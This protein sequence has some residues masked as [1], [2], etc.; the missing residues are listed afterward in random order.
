MKNKY[1]CL[2]VDDEPLALEAIEILVNDF[3]QFHIVAKCRNAFSALEILSKTDIDLVFLDINMPKL[4]G[5]DFLSISKRNFKVILTT[6]YREYALESYDFD[7]LD[8]LLKPI[9]ADRFSKAI[10]KFL[11][12][13]KSVKNEATSSIKTSKEY[14]FVRQDRKDVK[15][16][17]KEILFIEGMKDYIIIHTKKEKLITKKTLT[18]FSSELPKD[19]FLRVHKSYIVSIDKIKSISPDGIEINDKLIPHSKT[20]KDNIQN[21]ID[22]S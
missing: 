1:K 9:K 4:S 11:E 16:I 19:Q 17:L 2:I 13:S 7:V 8:Y 10:T 15:I 18:L 3:S 5:L 12:S 14:I 20:Y 21:L 6:A 22:I